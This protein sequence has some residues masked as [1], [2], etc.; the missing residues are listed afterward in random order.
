VSSGPSFC[1]DST[2]SLFAVSMGEPDIEPDLS[3]RKTTSFGRT[4]ESG[5]TA[6][7]WTKSIR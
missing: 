1:S 3:R 4:I 5:T 2:T 7:G 6:G